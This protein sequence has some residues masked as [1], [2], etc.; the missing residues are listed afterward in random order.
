MSPNVVTKLQE[1]LSES[2]S[3]KSSCWRDKDVSGKT[4]KEFFGPRPASKAEISE[5]Q[6][7]FASGACLRLKEIADKVFGSPIP[8]PWLTCYMIRRFGWP[9]IGSDDYKQLCT[10][11]LTTRI[12]GLYLGVT[13]YMGESNLHFSVLYDEKTGM[14]IEEDPAREARAKQGWSAIQKWWKKTGHKLYTM[15]H[16]EEGDPKETLVTLFEEYEKGGKPWIYGLWKRRP[17]HSEQKELKSDETGGWKLW[18]MKELLRKQHP[19]VKQPKPRIGK[20][21]Q[22]AKQRAIQLALAA[23][24]RD[25]LRMTYVRDIN[26]NAFGRDPKKK[27]KA[28]EP[29]YFE[30]AGYTPE[31]FSAVCKLVDQS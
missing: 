13:P 27:A 15:G 25:L 24:M 14:T 29:A 3:G 21:K 10:W 5:I 31:G 6:G 23:T 4:W 18:R 12:P 28:A 8:G 20:R 30:G 17:E 9:N 19:E 11:A 2:L 16:V 26:F 1:G 22:T 7:G